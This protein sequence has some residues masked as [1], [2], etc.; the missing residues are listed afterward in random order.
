MGE[1]NGNKKNEISEIIESTVMPLLKKHE[2]EIKE[3]IKSNAGS[4]VN[5]LLTNDDLCTVIFGKVYELVPGT[6]RLVLKKDL[7]TKYCLDNRAKILEV[8]KV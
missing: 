7:F 8:L 3:I 1:A 2:T 5:K 6:V 4:A